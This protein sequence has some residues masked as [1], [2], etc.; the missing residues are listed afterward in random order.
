M[1]KQKT[2][3]KGKRWTIAV[4]VVVILAVLID[5]FMVGNIAYLTKWAQCGSKPIVAG[6]VSLIVGNPTAPT[7]YFIKN[8]PNMIDDIKVPPSLGRTVGLYCT[9]EAAKDAL[10]S[11]VN[12]EYR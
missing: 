2:V 9:L 1:Q 7:K 4:I 6:E 11:G 10:P 8:N 3:G 12:V 5:V